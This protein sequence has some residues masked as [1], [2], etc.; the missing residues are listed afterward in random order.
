MTPR[1]QENSQN[2]CVTGP[3]P[4]GGGRP[5]LITTR[6]GLPNP[7]SP[8]A[9]SWTTSPMVPRGC[10]GLRFLFIRASQA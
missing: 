7:H 10:W 6:L 5:L 3:Y 8:G 4:P 1:T 9:H 2:P